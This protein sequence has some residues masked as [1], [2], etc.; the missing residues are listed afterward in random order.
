M[1][2]E[3]KLSNKLFLKNAPKKIVE[4]QKKK[5]L[6]AKKNLSLLEN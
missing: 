1:Y 6:D 3:K 4:D 5:L 2:F